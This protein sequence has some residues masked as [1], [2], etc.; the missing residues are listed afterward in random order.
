MLAISTSQNAG[1]GG[2]SEKDWGGGLLDILQ[3]PS[4][5]MLLLGLALALFLC[6]KCKS[7]L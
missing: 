3:L 2:D 1:V 4:I 5:Y 6:F 7:F